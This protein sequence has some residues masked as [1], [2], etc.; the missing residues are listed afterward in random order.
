VVFS[1]TLNL[2]GPL[3][4]LFVEE[5]HSI[6][7]AI[8]EGERDGQNSTSS[9]VQAP[10]S[11]PTDSR[12]P[13]RQMLSDLPASSYYQAGNSYADDATISYASYQMAPQ[14]DGGYGSLNE[15]LRSPTVY[16]TTGTGAPSRR[17]LKQKRRESSMLTVNNAMEPHRKSS[18]SRLREEHGTEF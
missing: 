15:A 13:R 10:A 18:Q 12:S 2:P 4:S 3:I 7:G 11:G 17:E 8:P 1:P 5:Q 14:G 16:S 6:F 9:P